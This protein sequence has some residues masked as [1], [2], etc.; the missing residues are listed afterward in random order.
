MGTHCGSFGSAATVGCSK[1][2]LDGFGG[3]AKLNAD[4][5]SPTVALRHALML[6][7][8]TPNG[9]E[10]NFSCEVWSKTSLHLSGPRLYGDMTKQGTRKPNPIGP[11]V[12]LLT[13]SALSRLSTRAQDALQTRP[14]WVPFVLGAGLFTDFRYLLPL[15]AIVASG[16]AAGTQITATAMFAVVS[17]A[18]LE[19]PLASR[20]AAPVKTGEVMSQA[21]AWVKARRH[22]VFAL[23]I[24]LLG[25]FLMTT[26]MGHV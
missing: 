10:T 6:G 14:L 20:L 17:L 3:A 23:I 8:G 16:A 22:Q 21:H 11:R 2:G 15:S 4:V 1:L 7:T 13:S 9:L 25:I 12:P 18:F 5:I 24:A 26:G 19:I